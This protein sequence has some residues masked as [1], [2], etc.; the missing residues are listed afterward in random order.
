MI[1]TIKSK[2]V[3]FL[4]LYAVDSLYKLKKPIIQKELYN[5]IDS[6]T[7]PNSIYKKTFDDLLINGN[8]NVIVHNKDENGKCYWSLSTF[9][10]NYKNEVRTV[11]N[12]V[13]IDC[14]KLSKIKILYQKLNKIEKNSSVTIAEKYLE[15]YLE[16]EN[17]TLNEMI[18][19]FA[20]TA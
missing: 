6:F 1:T 8:V 15:G 7:V 11:F 20:L 13:L 16:N 2:K 3:R 5:T 4:N 14:K 10:K 17:L 18:S 19:Y 12:E 9:F